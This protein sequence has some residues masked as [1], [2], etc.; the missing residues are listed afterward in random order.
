MS[1]SRELLVETRH[2]T[3]IY[4]V[5]GKGRLVADCD[6]N[7][8]FY[9]GRTLGIVG[10]SGCGKST[11][12]RML[13]SLERPTEGEIFYRGQDITKL[14][15]EMLRQHRQKIQ[16]IFQ[17][18]AAAFHPGMKVMDIVCEP[19]MNFKRIKRKEKEAAARKLLEMVELPG[20]FALRY[21]RE[22]S[23]GQRQRVGIARALALEPEL[24]ICDEA[25]SALDVSVQKTVIELLVKLQ[26]EKH[27]SY[28]FISHDIA[29]VRAVSHEV[30]VMYLGNTV[31]VLP[32]EKLASGGLHPYTRALAGS[33]IDLDTDPDRRIERLE[34]EPPSS[35]SVPEGC[36][37]YS[38]CRQRREVCGKERPGLREIGEGHQVACHLFCG[39]QSFPLQQ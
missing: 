15:G 22:M 10:E 37:F 31:E 30:A 12:M 38:R 14:K 7:L 36:P 25:T 26:K 18:P 20:D 39:P 29:L 33:V 2:V 17:D 34:G 6:V 5:S 16:M 35:L 32:G 21:P 24:V 23:G 19:L 3:K 28:A 13:V 27:I 1:E 8:K 9:R 11:L 4:P